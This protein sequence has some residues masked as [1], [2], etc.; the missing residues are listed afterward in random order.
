MMAGS[1]DLKE[2]Q[3]TERIKLYFPPNFRIKCLKLNLL[4]EAGQ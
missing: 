1:G 3:K 2:Q 4:L